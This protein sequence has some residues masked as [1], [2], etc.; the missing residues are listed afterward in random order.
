M[1]DI[2]RGQLYIK[3]REFRKLEYCAGYSTKYTECH[4]YCRHDV[5]VGGVYRT[6]VVFGVCDDV[7]VGAGVPRYWIRCPG[8]SRT[9]YKRN[10]NNA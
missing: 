5:W 3:R 10:S 9:V 7:C 6:I 2:E 1:P 8:F 4:L